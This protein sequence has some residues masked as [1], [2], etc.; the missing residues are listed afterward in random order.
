MMLDQV[1][2]ADEELHLRPGT[3]EYLATLVSDDRIQKSFE[4]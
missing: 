4:R 3:G 1:P 2:I